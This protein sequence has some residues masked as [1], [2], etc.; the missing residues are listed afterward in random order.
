MT[1]P[2]SEPASILAGDG[3]SDPDWLGRSASSAAP[4]GEEVIRG[5]AGAHEARFALDESIARL[6]E[7]CAAVERDE[8]SDEPE[9]R[10]LVDHLQLQL[11]V[12][13]ETEEADDGFAALVATQP[14]LLR[15]VA[16]LRAEHVEMNKA[17][18][19]LVELAA[20]GRPAELGACLMSL[21]DR[22]DAHERVENDLLQELVLVD[23]GC[24]G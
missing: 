9:L 4:V 8:P 10:R 12:H 19:S 16:A 15:R 22:F 21:L 18:A 6:R 3:I 5:T 14:R 17:L 23:E 7:L 11:T 20:T 24:G 1:G 13:F 2:Y